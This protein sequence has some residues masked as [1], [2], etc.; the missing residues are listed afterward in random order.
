MKN[1]ILKKNK[2]D[3]ASTEIKSYFQKL[4]ENAARLLESYFLRVQNQP[5]CSHAQMD[6]MLFL[7]GPAFLS[8]DN[9]SVHQVI[10]FLSLDFS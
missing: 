4:L 2:S 7:V 9:V 5:A 10:T 3:L 6:G 1:S 8:P